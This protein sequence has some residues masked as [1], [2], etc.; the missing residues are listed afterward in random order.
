MFRVSFFVAALMFSGPVSADMWDA[1]FINISEQNELTYQGG[2]PRI[3]GTQEELRIRAQLEAREY[4][5]APTNRGID[6]FMRPAKESERELRMFSSD[7]FPDGLTGYRNQLR[8]YNN[9]GFT[10]N[11]MPWGKGQMR[12]E[13]SK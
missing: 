2:E 13:C 3:I 10:C 11:Q 6:S 12:A 5:Q 9:N 8:H 1:P 4:R 7:E